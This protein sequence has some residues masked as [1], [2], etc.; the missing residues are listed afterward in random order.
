MA[1]SNRNAVLFNAGGAA[2]V[3]F[4]GGYM[5]RNFFASETALSCST[6]YPAGLQFA[7]DD[8]SGAPLTPI[9]LQSRAGFREWGLLGNAVVETTRGQSWGASLV[10]KLA[11]TNNAER[12]DQNGVG[13]VW[14]V[15]ALKA[16]QSACLS[17]HVLLPADVDTTTPG[18]LP[19]LVAE[20]KAADG[21]EA[22]GFAARMAWSRSGD[23]G[24]DFSQL[25]TSEQ[26]TSTWGTIWPRDRWVRVEQE[27]N[28]GDASRLNGAVSVWIDGKLEVDSAELNLPTGTS[29]AF[30]GVVGDI[31]YARRP[32]KY[33][34]V[35]VSPFVVQWR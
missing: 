5:V 24:V 9:S 20:A 10:V 13:F 1:R 6:R 30:S 12:P 27:I 32:T 21:S 35:K 23:V 15:P 34:A 4:L 2:L 29:V 22:A 25:K 33:A 14:P 18:H 17:Y 31:G 3:V 8:K 28:L 26:L 19:G 16:A 7:L 11:P